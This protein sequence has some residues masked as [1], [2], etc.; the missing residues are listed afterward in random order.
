MSKML[1]FVKLFVICKRLCPH[2]QGVSWPVTHFACSL[3]AGEENIPDSMDACCA[4][5]LGRGERCSS[6]PKL[7]YSYR[8]GQHE[9]LSY[10]HVNI[11]AHILIL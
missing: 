3:P 7:G 9:K 8:C 2:A 6:L 10:M 11:N 4:T 1:L 5:R